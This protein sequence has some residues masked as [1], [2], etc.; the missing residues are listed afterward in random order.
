MVTAG[1]D[2]SFK[3]IVDEKRFWIARQA[4]N[5]LTQLSHPAQKN[6]DGESRSF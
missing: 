1:N 5:Q 6:S 2:I 3:K 4:G